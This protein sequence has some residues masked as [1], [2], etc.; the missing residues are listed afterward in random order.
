MIVAL[1]VV[2]GAQLTVDHVGD[3]LVGS[4]RFMLVDERSR[5][6]VVAHPSHEI[7]ELGPALGGERVARMTKIMEVKALGADGLDSALPARHLVE[8]P[9]SKR[10]ALDA[11]ERQRSRLSPGIRC[12]MLAQHRNDGLRGADSPAAGSRLGRAE[13]DFARSFGVQS[14]SECD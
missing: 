11:G 6:A 10:A 13:Q 8:V 3:D 1:V 12:Q 5:L 9:P 7:P 14:S 2:P 4:A